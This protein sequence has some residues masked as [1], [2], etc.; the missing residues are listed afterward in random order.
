MPPFLF[1]RAINV[2]LR[3]PRYHQYHTGPESCAHGQRTSDSADS[4]PI[5]ALRRFFLAS[6][7]E[8][9]TQESTVS[10]AR[11]QFCPLQW[12]RFH[13]DDV[14]TSLR[15]ILKQFRSHEAPPLIVSQPVFHFVIIHSAK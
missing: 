13:A 5:D 9:G 7:I 15:I 2:L 11:I 12:K 8:Q 10:H 6:I 14:G 4:T 3:D 1:D